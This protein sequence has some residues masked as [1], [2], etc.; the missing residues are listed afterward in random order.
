MCERE[1]ESEREKKYVRVSERK[2]LTEQ[3]KMRNRENERYSIDTGWQN[4]LVDTQNKGGGERNKKGQI[5][6]DKS[7]LSKIKF[8]RTN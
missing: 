5:K 6:I 8:R 7:Q 1:R 3:E 4:A 2:R